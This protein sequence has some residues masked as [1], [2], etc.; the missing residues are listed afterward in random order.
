MGKLVGTS[1]DKTMIGSADGPKDGALEGRDELC[2]E[3]DS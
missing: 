3:E 1:F 2:V